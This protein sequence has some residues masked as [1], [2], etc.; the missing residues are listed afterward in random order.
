MIELKMKNKGFIFDIKK[1]AVH[2]GP[3]IRT[4]VF[5]KGCPLRCWWCHN[6]ESHKLEPEK[7]IIEIGGSKFESSVTREKIIGKEVTV[8]EVIQEIEKDIIFYDESGGG[9]TFSGGEPLLQIDFLD[10][11]LTECKQREISTTLDTSGY[12]SLEALK[13]ICD[14]IDLFLYDLKIIDDE[15][16]EFYTQVSNKSILKNL[17]FLSERQKNIIIRISII[18]DITNTVENITQLGEFI[19]SLGNVSEVEIL[20]YHTI[21]EEKYKKLR[22]NNRMLGTKP[23]TS[24]EMEEIGKKLESYGLQV[25]IEV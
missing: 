3:G 19:S 17:Q 16:H 8:P 2:D 11:L 21:G 25:K 1:Y 23:P 12:A 20:A 13:K 10:A 5:L 4:T 24:E 14:K 22:I 7:M 6:P 18:P 15:K 9:V